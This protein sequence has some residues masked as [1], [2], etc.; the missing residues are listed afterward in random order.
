MTLVRSLILQT[1]LAV[2][3]YLA[4]LFASRY[5]AALHLAFLL[6]PVAVLAGSIVAG[7]LVVGPWWTSSFVG[8]FIALFDVV[9]SQLARQET[10][11]PWRTVGIA[12]AII[13]LV[14]LVGSWLGRRWR[15]RTTAGSVIAPE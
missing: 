15:G 7:R 2:Y 9:L 10:A 14:G 5:V 6:E 11:P 4:F 12:A 13:A 8:I 1:S 3:T